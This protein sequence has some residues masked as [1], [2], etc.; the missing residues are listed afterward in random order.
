MKIKIYIYICDIQSA[1]A[2]CFTEVLL[3]L[4]MAATD[5]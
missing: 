4:L 1:C 3:L 5:L 2:A